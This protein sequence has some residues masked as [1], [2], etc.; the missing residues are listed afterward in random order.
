MCC[1]IKISE[2]T[3]CKGQGVAQIQLGYSTSSPTD[4]STI[5]GLLEQ[6][7]HKPY[8]GNVLLAKGKMLFTLVCEHICVCM[9][10]RE[11]GC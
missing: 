11:G 10:V 8:T 9:R 7:C 4:M 2:K 3:V 5:L 1:Y 6:S